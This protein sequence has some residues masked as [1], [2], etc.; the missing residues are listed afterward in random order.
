MYLFN[1]IKKITL[2]GEISSIFK[3][4]FLKI[5]EIRW[6]RKYKQFNYYYKSKQWQKAIESSELILET[7]DGDEK[8]LHRL[9]ICYSKVDR[10][11]KSK[12]YIAKSLRLRTNHSIDYIVSI[13]QDSVFKDNENVKSEYTYIGGSDNLGFVKHEYIKD[14][15]KYEYLTKMIPINYP[16]DHFAYKEEYFYYIICKNHTELKTIAAQAIDCM[17]MKK[18]RLFLITFIKVNNDEKNKKNLDDIININK[19]IEASIKY[20]EIV[21]ILKVTDKGKSRPFSS[22]MHKSFTHK[23]IFKRM[24]DKTSNLNSNYNI[25][26]FIGRIEHIMIGLKMYEHIEPKERYIFCHG[27]FDENNILYDK[28]SDTYNVIDWSGYRL[29]MKGYDLTKYFWSFGLS[30]KEIREIYL[31]STENGIDDI[32]RIF[33][34]YNFLIIS[35]ERLDRNKIDEEITERIIPATE[36]IENLSKEINKK[37]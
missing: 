9:A 24:K 23:V 33:F 25:E 1:T 29:G 16:M 27:D 4:V 37:S 8:L 17:E 36:Y 32:E 6:T 14:I 13:V 31:D 15:K 19:N 20:D 34:A 18:E 11:D 28:Q 3:E 5:S 21:E 22:L 30:F 12:I 10:K 7:E 26:E 35:I 2:E